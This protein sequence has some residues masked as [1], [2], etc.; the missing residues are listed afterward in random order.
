MNDM[1]WLDLQ[2]TLDANGIKV[3]RVAHLDV[4]V[5]RGEDV[6]ENEVV[7]GADGPVPSHDGFTQIHG[8]PGNHKLKPIKRH[9]FNQ[10]R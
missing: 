2:S 4:V 7:V 3:G 1:N 10:A 9:E 6:Q 8:L 5:V